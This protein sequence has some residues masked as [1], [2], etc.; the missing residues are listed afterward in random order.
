MVNKEITISKLS[1]VSLIWSASLHG[2]INISYF[3]S[4]ATVEMVFG[5]FLFCGGEAS[6]S[7]GPNEMHKVN[8]E[9]LLQ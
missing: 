7:V 6:F 3:N 2:H 4:L 8:D 1:Y 5:R 9:T